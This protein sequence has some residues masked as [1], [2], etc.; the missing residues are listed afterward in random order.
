MIIIFYLPSQ[1]PHVSLQLSL[2]KPIVDLQAGFTLLQYWFILDHFSAH[3]VA[4]A[5]IEQ[6]ILV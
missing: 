5:T 6:V 2:T 1:F 3:P 4:L